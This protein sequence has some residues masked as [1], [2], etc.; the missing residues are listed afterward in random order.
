MAN[1]NLFS[2][3]GGTSPATD[4]I[5]E[6]GGVAYSMSDEHAL[7]QYACTGCLNG[8]F[9]AS[10]ETQLDMVLELARK[11]KPLFLAKL[12]VYSRQ[13][14]LMKDMPAV[15]L[16]VLST[17]DIG[18]TKAVFA[19]VCDDAKM[20]KNFVQIIRS[21]QVGRKSLGTALKRLVQGWLA[22]RT[23]EQLFKAVVGTDPSLADVIKMVHPRP[24]NK[25][26]A[27]FYKYL[28]GK[29]LTPAQF[30]TLPDNVQAYEKFKKNGGEAKKVPDVPFQLLTNLNLSTEQYRQVAEKMSFSA[31]RQ[32]LNALAKHGVFKGDTTTIAAA[33]LSNPE[34]VRKAKTM[35]FQLFASYKATESNANVPT[36]IKNAIQDALDASLSNV[37]EVPGKT[38]VAVDISGSMQ[39]PVTGDRG[40]ATTSI[41]CL[42]AAAVMGSALLRKN[43]NDVEILPF[44]DNVVLSYDAP[45]RRDIWGSPYRTSSKTGPVTFNGRDSVITNVEKLRELPN[46]GT[47]CSSVLKH[48]NRQSVKGVTAVIYLSD[49]ESWMDS[50]TT[51][52]SNH[53]GATATMA[54]WNEFRKRNPK[55]KLVCIDIAPNRT[56]Q[57]KERPDILN[58]GGFSDQVFA[59]VDLFLRN[60]L[61]SQHFAGKIKEVEI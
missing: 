27:N 37:P 34:N 25:A 9:Y 8:T 29:D 45:L 6:A 57:A 15:L 21:G 28:I 55:A 35:P 17:R 46:N 18:L 20:V 51:S 61:D 23:E 26:R 38:F 47:N 48:L 19:R 1:R 56:L 39:S 43:P 41:S 30:K 13:S 5:N 10:A 54:E 50:R 4:T 53:P 12:A 49:N 3:T 31:L 36:K 33:T 32:N 44:S 42:D 59:I 24:A 7:A 14:G 60:E 40:S 2:R 58:I 11:V 16:A 22:E 52:Y